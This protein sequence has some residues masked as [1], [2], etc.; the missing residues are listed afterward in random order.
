[1]SAASRNV[2]SRTPAN[3]SRRRAR[4]PDGRQRRK[5]SSVPRAGRSRWFPSTPANFDFVQLV[6]AAQQNQRYR[7]ACLGRLYRLLFQASAATLL[8]VAAT[9]QHLGAHIGFL[10]VLHTWGQ[11]LQH[12]PHVH[13]LS[14]GRTVRRSHPLDSAPV[15]FLS[16]G[17]G[18]QPGISR[19]VC[20]GPAT[21]LPTRETRIHGDQKSLRDPKLFRALVRS[22]F[23]QDWIVYAKP[24]F[25]GPQYVLHYLARYTH[26]VAISNHLLISFQG[27]QVAFR[28]KDYAH[29]R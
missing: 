26:R 4:L 15:S 3:L 24:P 14:S 21:R 5:I 8:E 6:I 16:T 17:E 9:P 19:Q 29:G 11:N 13:C 18:S 28:W 23:C 20:G 7:P 27:G 10:S 22:L 25:G 2:S 1:M 12:H